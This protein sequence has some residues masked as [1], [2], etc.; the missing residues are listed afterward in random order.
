MEPEHLGHAAECRARVEHPVEVEQVRVQ[1]HLRTWDG[2]L[3]AWRC[4]L[5]GRGCSL[6]GGRGCSSPGAALSPMDPAARP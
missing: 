6:D 4:S 5:D 3:N 1:L 2:T